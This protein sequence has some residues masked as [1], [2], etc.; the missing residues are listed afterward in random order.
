MS[1]PAANARSLPVTIMQRTS[2]PRSQAS[3][4]SASS[5]SKAVFKAF[6]ASG[7]L[8]VAMPTEQF[9]SVL[10]FISASRLAFGT[11]E[12][13][14]AGLH[15]A[16]HRPGTVVLAPKALAPIDQEMMLEIAGIAGGLGMVAQ[17]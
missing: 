1:A 6:K 5:F 17:G 4:A 3:S 16:L 14:T 12:S 9:T 10:I 8:S 11:I 15:D 7:R 2:L 13:G